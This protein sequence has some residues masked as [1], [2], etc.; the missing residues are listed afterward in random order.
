[1]SQSVLL[2]AGR[3]AAR[4]PETVVWIGFADAT[5]ILR[6]NG[7]D[8]ARD[9]VGIDFAAAQALA[10]SGHVAGIALEALR[11]RISAVV[12]ALYNGAR[13]W[14]APEEGRSEQKEAAK[15]HDRNVAALLRSRKQLLALDDMTARMVVIV[16]GDV[17]G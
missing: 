8:L 17:I 13:R 4:V 7:A 15:D 16:V 10:C 3:V 11:V 1:M 12:A 9:A 2:A 14:T 6:R 5:G